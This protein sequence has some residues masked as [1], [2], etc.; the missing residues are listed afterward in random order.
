MTMTTSVSDPAGNDPWNLLPSGPDPWPFLVLANGI[1]D[2]L[3]GAGDA[4]FNYVAGQTVLLICRPTNSSRVTCCK[5]RARCGAAIAHAGQREL[6]VT[7]TTVR[8][9]IAF[10]RGAKRVNSI[11]A[12]A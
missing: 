6:S 3:A 4:H 5:C 8:A 7:S 2:Y 10:A 1:V 12:S 11:A 9:T